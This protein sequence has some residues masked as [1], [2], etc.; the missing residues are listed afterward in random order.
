MTSRSCAAARSSFLR[1]NTARS[2]GRIW[3]KRNVDALHDGRVDLFEV[4]ALLITLAALFNY[5]NHKFLRLPMTIG[6]M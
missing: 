3:L 1:P 4:I 6:I 5:V 2:F